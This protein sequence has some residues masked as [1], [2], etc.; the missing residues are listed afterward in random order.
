M[1]LTHAER[2]AKF[3]GKLS[4]EER[5]QVVKDRKARGVFKGFTPEDCRKGGRIAL[6]KIG[7]VY[8]LG[9]TEHPTIK[10]IA[11]AAGLY[12]GEG[13]CSRNGDSGG[14]RITQ[15]DR[16]VC[17]RMRNLFGGTVGTQTN[18]SGSWYIWHV[19][20]PRARGF[21]MTIFTFLSPRRRVQV[22]AALLS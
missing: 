12:E 21:L 14:A 19:S 9:P 15:K 20:G 16:W 8:S 11:W 1:G 22:K 18:R 7:K 10:D 4:P 6:S 2:G 17:D 5:R 13:S 3:W